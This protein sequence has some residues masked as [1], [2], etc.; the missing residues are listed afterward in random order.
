MNIQEYIDWSDYYENA[1]DVVAGLC[2]APTLFD[3]SLQ[4]DPNARKDIVDKSNNFKVLFHK[5]DKQKK[6]TNYCMSRMGH[7]V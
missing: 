4:C 3:L 7:H 6:V 5:L 1:N 2:S